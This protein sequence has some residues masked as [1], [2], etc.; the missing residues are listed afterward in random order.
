MLQLGEEAVDDLRRCTL[1]PRQWV[2]RELEPRPRS[3]EPQLADEP[4]P[5]AG[6]LQ[7]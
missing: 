7:T 1:L 4:G 5:P 6:Q 2:L 3:C